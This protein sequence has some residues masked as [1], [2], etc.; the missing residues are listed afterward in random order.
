MSS[1]LFL[2]SSK[3]KKDSRRSSAVNVDSLDES[4]N[5]SSKLEDLLNAT[6]I[7]K[8][9]SDLRLL[10]YIDEAAEIVTPLE[11]VLDQASELAKYIPKILLA[12]H[13]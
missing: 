8:V 12:F 6:A 5:N 2:Y 9:R 10:K 7:Y 3:G 4:L 13:Y 1:F 11:S